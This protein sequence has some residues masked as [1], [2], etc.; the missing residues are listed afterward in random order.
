MN[1]HFGLI[2]NLILVLF[3]VG[4]FVSPFSFLLFQL[5]FSL[6]VGFNFY[7]YGLIFTHIIIF[8]IL[9]GM[10]VFIVCKIKDQKKSRIIFFISSILL[11]VSV[12][13]LVFGLIIGKG[14][15]AQAGEDVLSLIALIVSVPVALLTLPIFG[16][17][18]DWIRQKHTEKTGA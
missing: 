9:L 12:K 17:I 6:L 13:A 15:R 16:L 11:L 18:Y 7:V 14:E 4:L 1:K 3:I 2:S 10:F 8:C 5:W